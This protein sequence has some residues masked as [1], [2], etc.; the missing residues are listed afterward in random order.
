VEPPAIR[1]VGPPGVAGTTLLYSTREPPSR[2]PEVNSNG[3]R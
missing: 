2:L 3:S 1:F